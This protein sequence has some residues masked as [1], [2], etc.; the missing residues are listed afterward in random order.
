MHSTFEDLFNQYKVNLVYFD[1]VHA[2]ERIYPVFNCAV[3]GYLRT[4]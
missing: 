2:Y 3:N 1:H 4:I